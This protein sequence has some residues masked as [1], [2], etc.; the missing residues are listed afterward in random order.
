[1]HDRIL[2]I[3]CV[4]YI[5]S[6]TESAHQTE[7]PD[8]SRCRGDNSEKESP[9]RRGPIAVLWGKDY[10]SS[11]PR[12]SSQ[13]VSWPCLSRDCFSRGDKINK[14]AL[15]RLGQDSHKQYLKKRDKVTVSGRG[16]SMA[17]ESPEE[18][19]QERNCT[20]VSLLWRLHTYCLLYTSPSPRD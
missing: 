8:S 3:V 11:Q 13:T 16:D 14:Q 2:Y 18:Q 5:L 19:S 17:R 6:V 12:D 10:V 20:W 9:Q 4:Y 1:M 15:E 7:S